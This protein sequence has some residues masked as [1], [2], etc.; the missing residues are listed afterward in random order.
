MDFVTSKEN[1]LHELQSVQGV[2]EKKSTLPILSNILLEAHKDR[3]ELLATN[4]EIG[5]RS[6]CDASVSKP[7][8]VTVSAR[9]LFDIVRYLPDAEVRLRVDEGNW[10]VLTCQKARFRIVSL[11]RE[12]FPPIPEFDF[13]RAIPI[14]RALLLDLIAKV[15][16]AISPDDTNPS[17][18]GA[19]FSLSKKHLTLVATDGHRLALVSGRLEKGATE[20]PIDVIVPRKTIQELPRI[21]EGESEVLFGQKDHHLFFRVGRTI[22]TTQIG[23]GKFPDYQKVIPEGNDKILKFDSTALGDVLR[24]VALLSVERMRAVKLH[25]TKGTLEISSNN[26]GVGEASET[27]DLDYDGPVLEI[28]FNAK[29]LLDFL[30]ALGQAQVILAIKDGDTQGLLRPVGLEGRDYRY[31]VMPMRV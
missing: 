3:L 30:Q 9:Q 16:F 31:V 28:G 13:N 8:A 19:L 7:G 17:I 6:T 2:V 14:E 15:G 21:G 20:A 24:R 12:D 29:Y 25:L 26:P 4:L 27:I 10:V 11:P 1:L 23:T 22:L 18:S 5:M